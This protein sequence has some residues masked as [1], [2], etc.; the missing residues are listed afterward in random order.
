MTEETVRAAAQRIAQHA[1]AHGL[2]RV[3]IVLHGGE[4]LLLG[5]R[6]LREVVEQLHH[7]IGDT[8]QV[9]FQLQTNG[10][11][12]TA[13]MCDLFAEYGVRVGVSLD[14]D[15]VA[16]DRHRRF[17]NGASSHAKVLSGLELLRRPE[18]RR[19]YGGLLCTVDIANDPIAVYEA[20][21]RESPPR[22]DFLLPHGTWEA[23]P[24]GLP[25]SGTPYA[26]W[27][28][29]I[30]R[31]WRSEG[32]PVPIRMF[33]SLRS[34][35]TGGPSRTEA[36]GLDAV[37]LAVL[38]TDGAWE[39]VDS[40]KTAYAG[41]PATGFDV[42]RHSVDEVAGHLGI[43]ARQGGIAD[44]CATCQACPVVASCGGG[45]YAHRYR[46]GTGFD[47]PSVYCQDLKKLITTVELSMAQE[48][49]T[50]THEAADLIGP[51][52]SGRDDAAALT[53]LSEV[54]LELTKGLLSEVASR[55]AEEHGVHAAWEAL[56]WLD[57]MAP[58][59]VARLLRQ[60]FV[61]AWAIGCLT[62]HGR[63]EAGYLAGLA[64]AAAVLSDMDIKLTVAPVRGGIVLPT[65]G[66]ATVSEP[67]QVRVA[68]GA[69]AIHVGGSSPPIVLG[70]GA[71]SD[72]RWLPTRRAGLGWPVVVEDTDP[73]RDCFRDPVAERLTEDEASQWMDRLGSAWA[74]IERLSPGQA[75]AIR[76]TV[77]SVVPLRPV[78]GEAHRSSTARDAFGA[79]SVGPVES[80]QPLAVLLVHEVQHVKLG[81]LLDLC[82]LV[83][84]SGE[85]RITVPWRD[86]PRPPEGVLQGVYAH[87]AVADIWRLRAKAGGTEKAEQH[88]DRYRLWTRQGIVSLQESDLLTE[89]GRE[90]VDHL[91]QTLDGWD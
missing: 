22:V 42:H 1:R 85:A 49:G 13:L 33:D 4:P 87:L 39:Q 27:L 54:Q 12:L 63:V 81:A 53:R 34:L 58:H 35:A 46:A 15:V 16:N 76:T 7:T 67:V 25:A 61:R 17:P 41:A 38:E 19:A 24:F 6:R 89:G 60:P 32:Q 51:I 9:E 83:Q 23:P 68:G 30:Y 56:L 29:I 79:V 65:V 36:L 31:R 84:K 77:H 52:A 74:E 11:G 48:A 45:L 69:A 71:A 80:A 10:I 21:R 59:A 57:D 28:L 44:L 66:W 72:P 82:D 50:T 73:Y 47:N 78:P 62:Q 37:D 20:L 43:K 91:S 55:H 2:E 14:G 90:F 86:D 75:A 8:A 64:A 18:Y 26:D 70:Q 3:G 88:F 5:A 40:L